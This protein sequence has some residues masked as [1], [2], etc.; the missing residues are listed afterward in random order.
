MSRSTPKIG[1]IV[2]TKYLAHGYIEPPKGDQGSI[3]IAPESDRMQD[4]RHAR[5]ASC[6]N[7]V[8][9]VVKLS[10]PATSRN[11]VRFCSSGLL[12]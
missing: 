1:R 3:R 9:D 11:G 4:L 12:C 10:G 5:S 6:F 2:E 8:G 7:T